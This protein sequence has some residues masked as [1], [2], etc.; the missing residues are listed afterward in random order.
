MTQVEMSQLGPLLPLVGHWEG[1]K[2]EDKAP[3][4]DKKSVETNLYREKMHFEYIGQVKTTS[5]RSLGSVTTPWL[6]ASESRIPFTKIRDIG[7]G[8]QRRAKC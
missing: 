4:D 7:S 1:I 3:D 5:N 8:T 2:G 6:G